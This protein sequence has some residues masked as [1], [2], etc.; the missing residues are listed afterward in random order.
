MPES[1]LDTRVPAV[2][3][4][5]DRNPFHHGTLGAV[6]SLGRAG[7]DVHVIADSTGSPVARSRFVQPAAPPAA[8]RGAAPADIAAVLLRVAARVERPAVLIPMD[9]AGAIAVSRLREELAPV[10][11]LPH[12]PR[13]AARTGRRQGR[14]GR[15]C[16]RRADV[17]HPVTAHPRQRGAGRRRRLAARPAGHREVE[18]ALAAAGGRG[19]AQHGRGALRRRKPATCICAPTRRAAGCCCRPSCRRD[20]DRDWFFHGY[21]DRSGALAA[22]G[23]RPQ[24]ARLA[25]RARASQRWAGGLP[26]RRW[27]QQAERLTAALGYRGILD[28]DF[29]LAAA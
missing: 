11:L 13:H 17:P 3:L 23:H 25:A 10:Y 26:T 22:G 1:P 21:A 27:R 2:L 12:Q 20:A 4:R 15:D 14:T 8:A 16:A 6:R 28:L 24:A 7:I 5:I 29:R 9:D 19:A 18:Q